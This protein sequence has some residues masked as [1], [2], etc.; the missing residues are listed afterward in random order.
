MKNLADKKRTE[1]TFQLGDEVFIKLQPYA[2][3]SV[4]SRSNHKLAFR[5]FGPYNI[6]KCVNPVAYEVAL[7]ADAR[8][9]PVFHVSQL[10]KVIRPGMPVSQVLPLNTDCASVPVKIL[11]QR[12]RQTPSGRREQVQVQW[13]V[14]GDKDITWEDKG[15]LLQR[16]PD[17]L[18]WGQASSQGA[19][20]VSNP[21]DSG[22]ATSN[23]GLQLRSGRPKRIV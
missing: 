17:A 5:Y 15:T 6:S 8:I 21:T 20:D 18:A 3:S 9:H 11:H 23:V 1:R 14:S 2:Q 22:N 10:R 16:F 19:G 7:P 4:L 12:W 13:T